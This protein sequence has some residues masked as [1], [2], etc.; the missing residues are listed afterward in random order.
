[1]TSTSSKGP[2][3]FHAFDAQVSFMRLVFAAVL[4]LLLSI[5]FA[6][7]AKP[8]I[9]PLAVA[10]WA[11]NAIGFYFLFMHKWKP[12]AFLLATGITFWLIGIAWGMF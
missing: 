11:A 4:S 12:G 7:V 5:T 2:S 9:G 10:G 8:P 6:V 1:M 3:F